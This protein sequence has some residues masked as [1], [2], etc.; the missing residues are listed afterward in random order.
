MALELEKSRPG[1]ERSAN[2]AGR[3]SFSAFANLP[4][5]YHAKHFA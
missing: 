1:M 5:I 3:E 4:A 2:D